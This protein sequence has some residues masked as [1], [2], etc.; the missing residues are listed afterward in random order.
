MIYQH[1]VHDIYENSNLLTDVKPSFPFDGKFVLLKM[2]KIT[3]RGSDINV[4][5]KKG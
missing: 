5:E 3:Q 1:K 2:T 4:D